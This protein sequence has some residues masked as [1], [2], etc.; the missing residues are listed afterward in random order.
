MTVKPGDRIRILEDRLQAAVVK[1]GDVLTVT[2]VGEG[3]C[4]IIEARPGIGFGWWFNADREGTGF[5]KV[6]D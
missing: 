4:G 1:V 6:E 5:E 3:S 2:A